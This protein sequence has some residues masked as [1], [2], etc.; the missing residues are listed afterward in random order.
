MPA[1]A[2]T[3]VRL[4]RY[5]R[6]LAVLDAV[7]VVLVLLA[8]ELVRFGPAGLRGIVAGHTLTPTQQWYLGIGTLLGLAWLLALQAWDAYD[9]RRAGAGTE[10]YRAV[11][12]ATLWT[13]AALA[14]TSYALRLPLARRFVL[15]TLPC[16][17]FGLLLV[18]WLSRQ[19]LTVRRGR[20]DL[21]QRVLVAGD[22]ARLRRL[23]ETMADNPAAG[24]R[25]VAACT[26]GEDPIEGV[27]VV[28]SEA[29]T[30]RL[31]KQLGV[32]A[33][34]V[35]ASL[36]ATSPSLRQLAWSLEGTAID[37]I[38]VP[39]L[40]DIAG[41][42]VRT[43]PVAGMALLHVEAPTF[44][45]HRLVAK[46]LLDKVGAGILV[47]ALAPLLLLIG[48]AVRLSDGGP[49]L[50]RQERVGRGGEPFHMIKFRTMVV[51]AEARRRELDGRDDVDRGP[52]FKLP[53]DPRVTPL[54]S[55]LRRT[56]L[57]ELPQLFNVLGG[58]MSLVGPR[59]PLPS[60]VAQYSADVRRRLL[61]KPG[62]TGLW[63]VSGRSN[64]TWDESVRFDL[65]YVENWSVLG[66][67][68]ILFRTVK[69]VVRGTGAY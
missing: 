35:S 47:V 45:G 5:V 13:F 29:D 16:G 42:R 14:I 44:S 34:A 31:A 39:G 28:G 52:L 4:S 50:F 2:S 17:L 21:M 43:R 46:T 63:Q 53:A 56:S 36:R 3:R 7:V 30:A 18:H 67:L 59:P 40:T 6:A 51:D 62:M 64:L 26:D 65:Y 8:A 38:V 25:V 24:Y 10:E 57:D 37:L 54:G 69:A 23:V 48:L 32:D 68:V 41:P 19:W 9:V 61:V 1:A 27:P 15:V 66:D 33:V 49:A 11:A 60:E 20:G 22:R 55:V 58:S 12:G